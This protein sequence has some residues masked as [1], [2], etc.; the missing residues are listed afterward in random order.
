LY[1]ASL[2]DGSGSLGTYAI[3]REKLQSEHEEM[4]VSTNKQAYLRYSSGVKCPKQRLIHDVLSM[5]VG[6]YEPT[7]HE[8]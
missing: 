7:T 2:H 3:Q 4:I 8:E 6:K 1:W 5:S